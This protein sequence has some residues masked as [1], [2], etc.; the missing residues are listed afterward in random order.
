VVPVKVGKKN[1][2]VDG[3]AVLFVRKLF[4]QVSEAGAAVE[5]ID[6]PVDAHLNTGGIAAITQVF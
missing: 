6:V 4:A 1:V 2:R 3:M 5:D